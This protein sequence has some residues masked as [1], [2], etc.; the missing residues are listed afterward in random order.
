LNALN[1]KRMPLLALLFAAA[2][3]ALVAGCASPRPAAVPPSVEMQGKPG[4]KPEMLVAGLEPV[5]MPSEEELFPEDDW[6][7]EDDPLE[8]F[9]IVADPLEPFNRAMFV[10][11]D[12]LY[13]WVLKPVAQGYRAVVPRPAR[14]G[15]RNFFT[16]IG[17][18]VRIVNNIL[19]GKGQAAEAELARFLYNTTVGVL[20][21]GNPAR[22]NP[23]LNPDSADLGQT[24][25][26]YGIGDGFYIVWPVLGP[27]T[28]RDS[29]GRFGDGWLYPSN[30]IEPVEGAVAA[31]ALDSINATSF[32]I[33]DYESLKAAAL[34]PY[35]SLRDAYI[36][37]RQAKIK[38]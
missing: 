7:W 17:A 9:Y 16:N 6:D 15:V 25:G 37:L 28:L 4:P 31:Y 8:D 36:Q 10:F 29:V 24:L 3:A 33:G 26:R 12:K 27:S 2:T 22:H 19:Q 30:Y 13:F 38:R 20:G 21:F 34:D 32:R 23:G 18:P 35:Q 14:T 5:A 1:M 11:N